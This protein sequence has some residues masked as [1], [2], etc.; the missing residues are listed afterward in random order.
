MNKPTNLYSALCKAVDSFG[1]RHFV[2]RGHL[3]DML[4][5]HGEN[6]AIQLSNALNP[7]N[8]DKSLNDEK[9]E[10]LLHSIDH[11]ARIVFFTEYMRQFGLKPAV[12]GV[13][14]LSMAEIGMALDDAEM[15]SSEAFKAGK[16]AIKYGTLT[17]KDIEAIIKESSESSRKHDEIVAMAEA[18]LRTLR[19]E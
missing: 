6:A 9:K 8:Y 15:E 19:S 18:R 3:A 4:G 2:T 7:N 12:M 5:F 17:Q 10:L 1:S 14:V 11:E 13:H 16:M